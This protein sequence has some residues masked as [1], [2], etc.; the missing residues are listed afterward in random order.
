MGDKGGVIGVEVVWKLLKVGFRVSFIFFEVIF[1]SL[2][3]WGFCFL[4][5]SIVYIFL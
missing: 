5:D 4:F 3:R 2:F 1:I